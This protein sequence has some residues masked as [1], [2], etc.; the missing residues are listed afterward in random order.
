LCRTRG[1]EG[2]VAWVGFIKRKTDFSRPD[3]VSFVPW[4]LKEGFF[5]L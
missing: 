2:V 4:N 3:P 1:I 5:S